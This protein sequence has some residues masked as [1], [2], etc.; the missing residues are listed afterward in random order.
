MFLNARIPSLLLALLFSA[1]AWAQPARGRAYIWVG[2]V[3][4][5]WY[6]L[7]IRSVLGKVD[8][9]QELLPVI[10]VQRRKMEAMGYQ[11]TVVDTVSAH[12][13]EKA[14]KDPATKAF[15][16]FGHGDEKASG[17]LSTLGGE[18]VTAGDIQG[19]AAAAVKKRLGP[20]STW[21]GLDAEERKRRIE[22]IKNA[23]LDL[24]YVYM[25]SCYGM[26][27]NS[28]PDALMADGGEFRGYRGKAYL[29]DQSEAAVIRGGKRTDTPIEATTPPGATTT[30]LTLELPGYWGHLAYTISG[31][32]LEPPT[33]S[34]RGNVGGRQYRGKLAGRTLTISG[35]AVSD[36]ESSGPGSG[37]YYEVVVEVQVG[38]ERKY[39]GYIAPK[40][41][42]LSQSFHLSVPVEP[43]ATS[44]TFSISLMEQNRNYGPHGWRVTG[45][46]GR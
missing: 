12:D 2:D 1:V 23:H 25:H 13:I 24:Q 10:A 27:D 33:G 11:V 45:S 20:P 41:E 17:T 30:T 14:L 3:N 19:W 6:S 5:P 34:D 7:A 38:K 26:K 18:D 9:Y 39:F 43:E 4:P 37:D 32:V 21:K 8:P 22:A 44:A 35:T 28:L 31:A 46:L 15:A 40:G 29:Q 42:K 36:N 16:F